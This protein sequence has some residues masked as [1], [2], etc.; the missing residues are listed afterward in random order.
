M[1]I[2]SPEKSVADDAVDLHSIFLTIQG[3]GPFCGTPAI[4]VRL[5]GCNL[6]CPGC[7]T[8]YTFGRQKVFPKEIVVMVSDAL[9]G[10]KTNLVVITGGEPFRQSAT[11]ELINLLV[12][13]GYCVQIETNGTLPP[14]PIKSNWKKSPEIYERT[15]AYIVVSPKAGKVHPSTSMNACAW[16][17]VMDYRSVDPEDG[18]P[19]L[20][21]GHPTHRRVARPSKF[22]DLIYLQPRDERVPSLMEN[23]HNLDA[24]IASCMK[25]GYI[26]Q[27][28]IHKIIGVE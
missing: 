17:Y 8:E 19:I 21:L 25:H 5:A 27:L 28:Q 12:E 10:S 24:C 15:G 4:F 18:L 23:S 6:Q 16:K 13:Q 2:Q 20:A 26:L 7:D 9:Q 3:E 14:P 11:G 22:A 1:N